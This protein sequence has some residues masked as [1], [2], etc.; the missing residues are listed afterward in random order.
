M[1]DYK[2]NQKNQA[3]E[4]EEPSVT[5][6][7]FL[8]CKKIEDHTDSEWD[9]VLYDCF[10]FLDCVSGFILKIL[11]RLDLKSSA[12]IIYEKIYSEL[13]LYWFYWL[14]K[15]LMEFKFFLKSSNWLSENKWLWNDIRNKYES[16]WWPN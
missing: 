7:D 4:E 15:C 1:L 13:F 5:D 3:K 8:F 6:N 10:M 9:T 12:H 14:Y 16:P 2:I 11:S